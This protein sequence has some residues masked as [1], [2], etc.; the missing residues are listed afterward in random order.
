M[1]L[2][3]RVSSLVM[4]LVLMLSMSL[5][6]LAAD[7]DNMDDGFAHEANEENNYDTNVNINLTAPD[8]GYYTAKEGYTYNITVDEGGSLEGATFVGAGTV[9]VGSEEN[10]VEVGDIGAG[11]DVAV[12]VYG[13][14]SGGVE[15]F[16]NAEVT[17]NGN[18]SGEFFGVSAMDSSTVTVDGNVT[19]FDAVANDRMAGIAIGA[20][21]TAT[22][23]VTGNATGGNALGE[24]GASGPAM[25]IASTQ[26]AGEIPGSVTVYGD[27][28]SGEALGEGSTKMPDIYVGIYDGGELS[29]ISVG[30][31][32][33]I[34]G[35]ALEGDNARN[36]TDE[37]LAV[38][39]ENIQ[40]VE[41]ESEPEPVQV[42]YD[43]HWGYLYQTIKM[44]KAGDEITTDIG[45]RK[46]MPAFII[47]AVRQYDVK[48]TVK[49]TGGD[50]LLI[51]KD[52]TEEVTGFVLL[53]DLAEMLKK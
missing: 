51:A 37:E 8:E 18:V 25:A 4:A 15:A 3:R 30:S 32:E 20:D 29:S 43:S 46:S 41:K 31:Y 17:V 48:L 5:T 7:Y 2:F 42:G 39:I 33:T 50:D 10:E 28:R 52:F 12:N 34:G 21:S 11:G 45:A 38:I 35:I 47:E 13:D 40:I 44:S 19:G 27:V 1:K 36:L 53:T 14:V 9:N 6:V 16:G 24:N 26:E 23:T 49:W 22:V